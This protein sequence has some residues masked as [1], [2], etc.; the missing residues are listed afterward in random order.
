MPRA[1]RSWSS[2]SPSRARIDQT[3]ARGWEISLDFRR[4]R[5]CLSLSL[6]SPAQLEPLERGRMRRIEMSKRAMRRKTTKTH[7]L[8]APS[9]RT[10][11]AGLTV[12]PLAPLRFRFALANI[13]KA[14]SG[15]LEARCVFPSARTARPEAII[16]GFGGSSSAPDEPRELVMTRVTV[17]SFASARSANC[18]TASET[19][20][21][22]RPRR[23]ASF[24]G[25]GSWTT[26]RDDVSVES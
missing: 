8:A 25:Q 4:P 16:A 9:Q 1:A 7:S 26:P 11:R 22:R 21:N 17:G 18:A 10:C 20:G 12:H 23:P 19:N 2:S 13:N 3:G 14:A 5:P 6:A 15:A 24:R